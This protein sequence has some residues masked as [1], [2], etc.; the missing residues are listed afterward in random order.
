MVKSRTSGLGMIF[1]GGEALLAIALILIVCFAP[2]ALC[3]GC[4]GRKNVGGFGS[5]GAADLP[6]RAC[7]HRGRVPI[8]LRWRARHVL[9]VDWWNSLF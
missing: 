6:C 2:L 4:G 9:A 1:L 3:P 8:L 7:E 5:I